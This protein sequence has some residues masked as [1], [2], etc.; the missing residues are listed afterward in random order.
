MY[1]CA[2]SNTAAVFG[3]QPQQKAVGHPLAWGTQWFPLPAPLHA[4]LMHR[5]AV[6]WSAG[7]HP[8]S[9]ILPALLLYPCM[10]PT[11]NHPHTHTP[12]CG[13]HCCGQCVRRQVHPMEGLIA[14]GQ[15][16]QQLQALL[17]RRLIHQDGLQQ[18]VT[19]APGFGPATGLAIPPAVSAT[20]SWWFSNF[21]AC[22]SDLT[23]SRVAVPPHHRC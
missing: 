5:R 13:C 23:G 11:Y 15:A 2:G 19:A 3:G 18:G 8:H 21:S 6:S 22:F 10:Q 7:P 4:Q 1:L 16:L 17:G 12:L 9:H 14:G 20:A